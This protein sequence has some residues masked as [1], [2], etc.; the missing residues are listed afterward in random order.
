MYSVEAWG[1][2]VHK[3]A[4]RGHLPHHLIGETLQEAGFAVNL[5]RLDQR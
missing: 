1:S 2:T 4:S 3:P 5:A